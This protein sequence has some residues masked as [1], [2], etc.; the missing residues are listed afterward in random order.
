MDVVHATEDTGCQLGAEGIPD[1]VLGLG[2]CGRGVAVG[3][4]S[5]GSVD[6]DALLAVDGLAGSQVLGDEEILFAASDEDTSVT[7]RLLLFY[8]QPMYAMVSMQRCERTIMTFAP[9]FAPGPP[10]RPPPR[11]P[12]P[13]S[14]PLGAPRPP[15]APPRPLSPKPP[16][17]CQP[18]SPVHYF[19]FSCAYLAIHHVRLGH[20]HRAL[21]ELHA[22]CRHRR[23]RLLVGMPCCVS[24]NGLV[25]DWLFCELRLEIFLESKTQMQISRKLGRPRICRAPHAAK[26]SNSENGEA[27]RAE[28][29]TTTRSTH[30]T[31]LTTANTDIMVCD[32]SL[33]AV[34]SMRSLE[35]RPLSPPTRP[36]PSHATTLSD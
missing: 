28:T 25:E 24:V 21:V 20:R 14:P 13:R 1:A 5:R 18:F 34:Y 35:T 10:P 22:L 26:T 33:T 29:V 27:T 31:P 16:A 7:V 6:G 32:S 2:G 17:Y 36:I 9:P 30:T 3:G 15:R 12:R 4:C 11:P 23:V 8:C 19:L